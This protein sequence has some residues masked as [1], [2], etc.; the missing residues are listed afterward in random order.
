MTE[1]E[2][3]IQ[4]VHLQLSIVAALPRMTVFNVLIGL[5]NCPVSHFVKLFV[6][7]L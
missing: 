3:E 7:V 6:F 2:K 4:D 1:A 5:S